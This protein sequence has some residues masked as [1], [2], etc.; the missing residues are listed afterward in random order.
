MHPF[1]IGD[2]QAAALRDG[3]LEVANDNKTLAVNKTKA[4]VDAVLTANS[5]PTDTLALSVQ[6]LLVRILP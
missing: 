3:G 6:P 1:T 5:L 4:E 2:L